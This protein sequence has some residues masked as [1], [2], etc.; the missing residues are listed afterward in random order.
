MG[1]LAVG[2]FVSGQGYS[3]LD[4]LSATA[5][6]VNEG[7]I[8]T[9]D[10]SSGMFTMGY[11]SAAIN[12]GSVTTGNYDISAF[13][14]HAEYTAD[15]F[16]QLRY[17]VAS[18]GTV[19]SLVVND[20]AI[21]TGNGTVGASA[22]MYSPGIGIAAQLLQ[23][24]GGVITTGDDSIGARVAGNYYGAFENAGRISVGNDSVGADIS[25]GGVALLYGRHDGDDHRRRGVWNQR[26]HHRD[27]RQLDRHPPE[28]RARGC[29][30]QRPGAHAAQPEQ[31]LLL[32]PRRLRY[33]RRTSAARTW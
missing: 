22:R 10:N 12:S 32:L 20:G 28:R 3:L 31:S 2:S 33:G 9:G 27:R 18:S 1:E 21:T 29:S 11:V 16:A 25:A 30:L 4:P 23:N 17:G 19:L 6:N 7:I 15:E 14:P 26:R 5:T 8:T 13:Q 24:E